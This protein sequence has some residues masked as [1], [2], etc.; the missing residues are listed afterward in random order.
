MMKTFIV[1]I[2]F[3]LLIA[4]YRLSAQAGDSIT[5]SKDS[6]FVKEVQAASTPQVSGQ[7]VV[8][9]QKFSGQDVSGQAVSGRQF[10][11]QKLI[12]DY[13]MKRGEN[14][15][16]KHF[17]LPAALVAYGFFGLGN[18]A[19]KTLDRSTRNEIR[20][21]N[22]LFNS[23]ID[24]YTQFIPGVTVFVLNSLGIHG[25]HN[26]KDA[27]LIYAGSITIASA[28]V[29]PIKNITRVQRPDGSSKNSFPSGHT[30]IAFAS[31]EFLRREYKDVSPW[32]GVAGYASAI[33][34]GV[35]RMYNNRHWFTDVVAGA[36]FGMA[37]TLFSYMIYDNILKKKHWTFSVAPTY[38][39]KTVGMTFVKRF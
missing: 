26:W 11:N 24:N 4:P 29:I 38:Y 20:E 1:I 13:Q 25:K 28:F 27:A 12:P 36:G 5:V 22:P 37:S 33:T 23:A 34:T 14:I 9:N 15:R 31:A 3:L 10:S 17:I 39:D 21:D 8:P 30:A 7:D 2:N 18:D 35:L 32:I 19:L 6:I 16:I